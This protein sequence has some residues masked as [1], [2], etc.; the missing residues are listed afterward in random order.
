[1]TEIILASGSK[2]RARMLAA[3]GVAFTV[4]KPNVDED[5]VKQSLRAEGVKPRDQADA[6]AEVKALKV[7]AGRA[8]LVIGSDQMLALGDR[9][10]DKPRDKTEAAS[11]LASFSGKTHEL[12]TAVV[13]ARAG[14]I[15]WRKV[16]VVKLHMR[17]L[18]AAF[19]AS[20]LEA[21][22]PTV[23]E[24]VG[25]YQIEGLGAQLFARIEGDAFTIQGLPLLP[26]LDALR[27]QGALPT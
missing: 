21:A 8:G 14:A 2:A 7:S 26:L 3:A 1:M 19:I 25:A 16:E 10:F 6:L 22:G 17:P 27:T 9:L 12:L 13:L 24:S 11:H 5:A 20:Y 23:L 18:S 4:V 15:I